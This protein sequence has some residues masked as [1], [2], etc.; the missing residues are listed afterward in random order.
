MTIYRTVV[1]EIFRIEESKRFS[2]TAIYIEVRSF[3]RFAEDIFVVDNYGN[4]GKR[5]FLF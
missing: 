2:D 4:L 3:E 5:Y 1:G